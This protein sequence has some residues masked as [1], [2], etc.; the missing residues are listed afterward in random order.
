[1]RFFVLALVPNA[2]RLSVRFYIEDDFGVI[3]ERY[4]KHVQRM[5]IEPPREAMPSMR[6]RLIETAM[7]RKSESIVPNLAGEWMRASLTGG[8]Y[9]LTLLSQLLMRL[10]ADHDVNA[11]RIAILKSIPIRNFGNSFKS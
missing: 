1:V 9:P 2:A 8:R 10:R 7:L 6:R 3:A 11:L 4:A 5:R